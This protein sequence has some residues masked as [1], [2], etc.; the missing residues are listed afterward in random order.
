MTIPAPIEQ[1]LARSGVPYSAFTHAT[2]FTAQEE[3]AASHVR[4]REWAKT[5]VCFADGQPILAVL[6]AHYAVDEGRLRSLVG[7]RELR[8][9]REEEMAPLYPSCDKGAQP[10]FGPLYGQKVFV[11]RSL[12]A[13]PEIVF[14]GGTHVDAIRMK[15]ADFAALVKPVLGEFGRAPVHHH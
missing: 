15:Y 2:A 1:Y 6:P 5:V 11:D 9:A 8:L 10:P 7:A 14:H 4:G 3:A 12:A 13:D